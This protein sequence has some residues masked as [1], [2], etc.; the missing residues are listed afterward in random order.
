MKTISKTLIMIM[1]LIGG[2]AANAQK[3]DGNLTPSEK[4]FIGKWKLDVFGMPQGDAVM[5]LEV[6]K[7]DGVLGGTIGNEGTAALKL[8]KAEIKDNTLTVR[9]LGGGW[10]IPLYLDKK[11][12][13]SVTGSMNDMFDIEGKKI[14][15]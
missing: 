6:T 10:D 1:L 5:I 8:T 7:T 4:Y 3:A 11:D 14:T 2:F 15:K 9:F 13:T 12:E